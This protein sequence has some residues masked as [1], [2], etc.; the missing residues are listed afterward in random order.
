MARRGYCRTVPAELAV[1]QSPARYVQ[2][3]HA[4]SHLGAE[5]R[6]IGAEGPLLIIA[7]RTPVQMLTSVWAQTLAEHDYDFSVETFGGE[8]TPGEIDRLGTV[9]R[10]LAAG[11]VIGVGG[12]KVLD[13]SRA[14][15]ADLGVTAVNCPTVASSDAPCS[16][17]SVVYSPDGQVLDYR[18]YRSNPALVVVDTSVIAS[19]P[20]RLLVAGL[21]DALATWWEADTVRRS[22]ADNQLHGQPLQTGTALAR[23]C[24]QLLL[25]NGVEAVQ[26]S[27]AGVVTPALERIIEANTLLSGLGFESGGLAAAHSIHNGLTTQVETHSFLHG[28]KVSFGLITQ[29]VLEGRPRADL[30]E[31]LAFAVSVRLPVTLAQVG[32]TDPTPDQIRQIAERSVADGET[33]HHEPFVVTAD[34]VADS[35]VAADSLGREAAPGRP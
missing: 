21:G 20:T 8:C 23:L 14:V 6:Q 3:R 7:S 15:A 18:F 11:A 32:L 12:G 35:I 16:A 9:A 33:I 29:M 1:F 30:D 22:C 13:T 19:A 26:A 4:T 10:S 31:V 28:E 24:Y 17:L 2:G 25:D 34:A 5:L 27:E